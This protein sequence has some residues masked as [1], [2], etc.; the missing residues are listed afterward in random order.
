MGNQANRAALRS[1]PVD[2]TRAVSADN[3]AVINDGAF[4]IDNATVI[5]PDGPAGGV[6]DGALADINRAGGINAN[7][8]TGTGGAVGFNPGTRAKS[9]CADV[10]LDDAAVNP[11]GVYGAILVNIGRFNFQAAAVAG[12]GAGGAQ[13]VQV[14][15]A[16]QTDDLARG[17]EIDAPA[18][19]R[20]MARAIR[21]Q[22][23]YGSPL[24]HDNAVSGFVGKGRP[25]AGGV[26]IR[27][28]LDVASV[29]NAVGATG[30]R[31]RTGNGRHADADRQG[32]GQ[33]DLG[34]AHGRPDAVQHVANH[35][36]FRFGRGQP[37]RAVRTGPGRIVVHGMQIFIQQ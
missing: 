18:V 5:D 36:V 3:A 35:R 27:T 24:A 31:V 28:A 13:G 8:A 19:T 7:L 23:A 25:V 21:F 17:I 11:V 16:V 20:I 33:C 37:Q 15:R 22:A 10:I 4:N 14:N 32:N 9:G 34:Q 2:G 1:H 12:V 30:G 6:E 29:V 26:V